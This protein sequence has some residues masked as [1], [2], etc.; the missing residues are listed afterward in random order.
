[1]PAFTFTHESV[2]LAS[3]TQASYRV[4]RA[5][6]NEFVNHPVCCNLRATVAEARQEK[7]GQSCPKHAQAMLP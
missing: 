6:L 3:P 7:L 2:P 1:M 5:G 4:G